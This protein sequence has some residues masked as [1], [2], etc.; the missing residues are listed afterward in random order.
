MSLLVE[1]A[2][3]D[4]GLPDKF[5]EFR[6]TQAEALDWIMRSNKRFIGGSAPTGVGKSLLGVASAVTL[7]A[8][9]VYLTATKA[10]QDQI[11]SD[12]ACIGMR[13]IRGRANYPCSVY[14]TSCEQGNEM[15]C[16]KSVTT[17]CPYFAAYEIAKAA[18]LISTNYSYWLHARS[19][20][21]DA[22]Q[23]P[24]GEPV[25]LLICDEA[26]DAMEELG[27]FLAVYLPKDEYRDTPLTE[28][29]GSGLM[30]ESSGEYWKGWA[31]KRSGEA[32][33]ELRRMRIEYGSVGAAKQAEGER[34]AALERLKR[35]L[36]SVKV[37]HDNWVW[38]VGDDGVRFE[39]IWPGRYA[40]ALWSGVGRIILLS[41]T[42][43]PYTLGLLGLSKEQYEFK[44]FSNGW[45]PNR[46]HVYYLPTAR[47]S[48]KSTNDDYA[49]VVKQIDEIIDA[50]Y[51][52]KGIVHTV[53]YNRMR[54]LLQHSRHTRIMYFNESSG[55]SMRVA[56]R[57]RRAQPP[58][59]LISP[60]Y[61]TGWDFA[62]D[63]CEYQII[64][65][66]PFPYAESRVMQERV[67]DGSFRTYCAILNLT[68]MIGRGRRAPDDRCETF[69]LDKM[70][71]LVQRSGRRFSA[72][73]QNIHRISA[74]PRVP[75]KILRGTGIFP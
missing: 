7:D 47:L 61:G 52:R 30:S 72:K 71:P 28:L 56:E 59:V 69:I 34:Y 66:I 63:Q 6:P 46:E 37:M 4:L 65:K 33:Y 51:D 60:S 35:K 42:L 26:H 9:C 68:Q 17:S 27:R 24:E 55:E 23:V 73:T 3:A 29:T 16:H 14:T 36:D 20:S 45:P 1:I 57:F 49:A 43:W 40:D 39:C 41:A 15:S 38:E 31:Q 13:D 19:N 53:S 74:V 75:E 67:R 62:Y 58:A 70:L 10:L 5:T 50:R 11:Q 12:F 32:A 64:P 48:Y 25:E 22:L 2:P 21:P 44:S 8:K 18:R 54:R